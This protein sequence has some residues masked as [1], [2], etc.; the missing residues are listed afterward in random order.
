MGDFSGFVTKLAVT[1]TGAEVTVSQ[2]TGHQSPHSK[3]RFTVPLGS[4]RLE[5]CKFALANSIAVDITYSGAA[6]PWSMDVIAIA[7][8]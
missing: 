5:L 4:D 7:E 1:S 6:E 3:Q 2:D 8:V